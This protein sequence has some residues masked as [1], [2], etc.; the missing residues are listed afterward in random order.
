[1]G[2]HDAMIESI[3]PLHPADS[4]IKALAMARE[5]HSGALPVVDG[6]GHPVGIFTARGLLRA[7]LPVSIPLEGVGAEILMQSEILASAPGLVRRLSALKG[8]VVGDVMESVFT[9]V[10][11]D[12]PLAAVARA[13]LTQNGPVFVVD[14]SGRLIGSITAR[15]LLLEVERLAI[16][17]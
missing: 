7:R 13:L 17:R 11:R 10:P 2:I 14:E 5:K 3:D 16:G 1:M 4:V 6:A 8:I 9:T 15:S 12:A